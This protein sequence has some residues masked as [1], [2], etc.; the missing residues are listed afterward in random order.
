[1]KKILIVDDDRTM[2]TVLTRYLENRG[3]Q[4]E[5]VSSGTEAL[6]VLLKTHPT[7]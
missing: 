7:W 4:V 2:R 6:A 3:Y 1:M 5:Q